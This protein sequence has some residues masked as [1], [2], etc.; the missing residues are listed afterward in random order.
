M[1]RKYK[2]DMRGKYIWFD[3]DRKALYIETKKHKL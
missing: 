3:K 2:E 1:L